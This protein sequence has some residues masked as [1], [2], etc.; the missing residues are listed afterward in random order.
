MVTMLK[1]RR[2]GIRMSSSDE[3]FLIEMAK[4][5]DYKFRCAVELITRIG[6]LLDKVE[7]ELRRIK[8]CSNA[9]FVKS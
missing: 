4:N 5:T 9:K 3:Y 1:S 7:K 6:K 2:M 8:R